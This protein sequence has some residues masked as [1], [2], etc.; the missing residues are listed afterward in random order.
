[1][2][3]INNII[4]A[5]SENLV[6][7][8]SAFSKQEIAEIDKVKEIVVG[9]IKTRHLEFNFTTDKDTYSQDI[10]NHF[11]V[12][13]C[14]KSFYIYFPTLP[15]RSEIKLNIGD[16]VYFPSQLKHSIEVDSDHYIYFEVY[17][18]PKSKNEEADG[19]PYQ[20]IA[21]LT[22][23]YETQVFAN[24]EKEAYAKAYNIPLSD[25]K[26]L[27]P[28]GVTTPRKIIRWASWG[29]FEINEIN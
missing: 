21:T 28:G 24:S 4:F 8:T 22:D 23:K 13:V 14:T 26:H 19:Q 10:P 27:T 20:I 7:T 9:S 1:M 17:Y 29:D 5:R 11:D 15:L 25:W 12:F 6:I 3:Q 2:A 16:F 18:W